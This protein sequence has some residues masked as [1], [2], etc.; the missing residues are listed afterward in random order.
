MSQF[1]EGYLRSVRWDMAELTKEQLD[2]VIMFQLM[3]CSRT[4][5][6][7][8]KK[9]AHERQRNITEYRHKNK[10]V[11]WNKQH[12]K[13]YNIQLTSCIIDLQRAIPIY[14]WNKVWEVEGIKKSLLLCGFDSKV[15]NVVTKLIKTLII[16]RVHGNKR[17][18]PRHAIT[19]NDRKNCH[20][21]RTL[22]RCMVSCYPDEYRG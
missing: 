15:N 21:L 1:D 5:L 4:E 12:T 16:T 6:T 22:Q 10:K 7:S 11:K 14:S 8:E 17:H 13:L 2:M 3:V 20:S 9:V 18:T 19:H